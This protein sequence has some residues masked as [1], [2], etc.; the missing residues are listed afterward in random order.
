MTAAAS[1]KP[2]KKKLPEPVLDHIATTTGLDHRVVSRKARRDRCK[3]CGAPILRGLDADL[4]AIDVKVDNVPLTPLGEVVARRA[5][6][7][8]WVLSPNPPG[9]SVNC[10]EDFSI[11]AKPAGSLYR[12]DV[13]PGHQCRRR[14]FA[15]CVSESHLPRPPTN[16]AG[17]RP[18]F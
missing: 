14:W 9:L 16:S 8:T 13:V 11:R 15:A 12:A 6:L 1:K 7:G 18:P 10:R 17:G 2:T 5:G 3:G 4:L